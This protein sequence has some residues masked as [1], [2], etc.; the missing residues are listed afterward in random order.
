MIVHDD[1]SR[2]TALDWIITVYTDSF[3]SSQTL[4]ARLIYFSLAN[5][6]VAK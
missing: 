3:I 1:T 6:Q 2:T 4:G 5:A